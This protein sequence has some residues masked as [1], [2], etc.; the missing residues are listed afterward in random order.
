MKKED[1]EN[2]I[3]SLKLWSNE[4]DI[5]LKE[6]TELYEYNFHNVVNKAYCN[7]G[8]LTLQINAFESVAR[9]YY[10]EEIDVVE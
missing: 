6:L 8:R 9:L 10:I 7:S 3:D 4:D 5:E 2:F 1:A